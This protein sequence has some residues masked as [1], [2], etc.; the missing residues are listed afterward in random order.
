V[1]VVVVVV[2]MMT[3]VNS[4][5]SPNNIGESQFS[6]AY[7]AALAIVETRGQLNT[8]Y[9]QYYSSDLPAG[10]IQCTR[11][12][13]S[14]DS[15]FGSTP[16]PCGTLER[17]FRQ[18][19]VITSGYVTPPSLIAIS[20]DV[21]G[22]AAGNGT[23]Y[24]PAVADAVMAEISI[25]YKG[26][27]APVPL[28]LWRGYPFGA[29]WNNNIQYALN[30][31]VTDWA[32]SQ[33]VSTGIFVTETGTINRTSLA[34]FPSCPYIADSDAILQ[35]LRPVPA[36]VEPALNISVL[37]D[38]GSTG[39]IICC[40][41]GTNFDSGFVTRAGFTGTKVVRTSLQECGA[42][43]TDGTVHAVYT[44]KSALQSL[45]Q[46]NTTYFLRGPVDIIPVGVLPSQQY[47]FFRIDGG[48]GCVSS[49]STTGMTG[50]T[51]TTGGS[52]G[53]S[54]ASRSSSQSTLIA[55]VAIITSFAFIARS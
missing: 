20:G 16:K 42:L 32:A 46:A 52:T 36:G 3:M 43:V 50:M 27:A 29:P 41:A 48:G 40:Q 8:I 47:P 14:C 38:A 13:A 33:A 9:R 37:A 45:Y 12:W 31:R 5:A 10:F 18:G 19:Y 30:Q 6:C 15:L 23:G 55:I 54:A 11:T 49:S 51:G 44:L 4:Q 21:A 35:G 34:Q 25:H 17:V 2:S 26:A 24:L 53:V 22:V 7:E 1:V 39:V 28:V